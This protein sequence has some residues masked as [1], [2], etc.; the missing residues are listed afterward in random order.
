MA[1][2]NRW[3][4]PAPLEV[5][6]PRLPWWTL[7][8]WKA[9]L[10]LAPLAAVWVVLWLVG[11]G[12]RLV[13]F[14]PL[15]S[16]LFVVGGVAYWV[17]RIWVLGGLALVV[18]GGLVWWHRDP[19]GFQRRVRW[20]RTEARRACLYAANWRTVTR[21]AGLTG[22]AK[23]REY[24]PTLRRTRSEWWRDRV[25]V[26]MIPG[27]APEQWELRASGLAHSFR[28]RSCRVRQVKPGMIELDFGHADPLAAS[29]PVPELAAADSTVDLRRVVIGQTETGK[30]WALRLLGGQYLGVGVQGAG[31]ASVLWSLLWALAPAIRS[32]A[33]QVLGIDPKG[34]MELG[35]APELFH[36]GPV[37]GNGAAAVELLESVAEE[38]RARAVRFR[39]IRRGWSADSGEPF[40]L[41]VLDELADVIAYQTDR[42]LKE[43]AQ[44]AL[45]TITS[46]GRAPGVAVL[47][48]VQDPRKEIVPF[49]NLFTTRIALRL[50]EAAQVDMVLGDGVRARGANAH[51]I[52]EA[53]PGVAWIKEDGKRDPVRARAFHI[54]D[55]NIIEL[56]HYVTGGSAVVLPFSLRPDGGAAA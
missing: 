27:Q 24:L 2:E 51:E 8:P 48:L 26:R 40:L 16:V 39:G 36:G 56:R 50:D 38:V 10:L 17:A 15:T 1:R 30:P 11:R 53:T 3:V 31:K 5:A 49:R 23:G 4:D 43:R 41:L 32:G 44:L 28:A 7:L 6:R 54:T 55:T 45:Q 18:V 21:L 34:G 20:L 19:L 42:K 37:Y 13:W 52:P 25:R 33:V 12:V 14:Y 46:Q 29:L 47:A 22:E 9:K 35:Q